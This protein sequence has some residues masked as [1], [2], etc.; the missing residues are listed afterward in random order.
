MISM[1]EI[2]SRIHTWTNLGDSVQSIA[3]FVPAL[4]GVQQ[5]FVLVVS[6]PADPERQAL[7][8]QENEFQWV[9]AS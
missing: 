5:S 2:P 4:I 9:G 1:T 7:A 3:A 8:V 6:D